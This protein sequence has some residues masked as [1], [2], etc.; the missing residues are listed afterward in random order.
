MVASHPGIRDTPAHVT[1][2]APLV[3]VADL[4]TAF[5]AKSTSHQPNIPL[6][7][8]CKKKGV[9]NYWPSKKRN[10]SVIMY[11]NTTY[12]KLQAGK[13]LQH[14]QSVGSCEQQ[15]G[16]RHSRSVSL[17]YHCIQHCPEKLA[18]LCLDQKLPEPVP[19]LLQIREETRSLYLNYTYIVLSLHP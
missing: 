1:H 4:H 10:N 16:W 19:Q 12:V 11:K 2:G 6:S 18:V 17:R 8:G 3:L 5:I 9:V 15:E 13:P 7:A 14:L